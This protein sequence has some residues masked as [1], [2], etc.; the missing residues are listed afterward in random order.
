MF[1]IDSGFQKDPVVPFLE[2]TVFI[3]YLSPSLL[4]TSIFFTWLEQQL[5]ENEDLILEYN[6]DSLLVDWDLINNRIQSELAASLWGKD[7]RYYIRLHM[8]KQFQTALEN[9]GTAKSFIE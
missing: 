1:S 3:L 4:K 2:V 5:L 8:D 6:P 9:F 7:Y